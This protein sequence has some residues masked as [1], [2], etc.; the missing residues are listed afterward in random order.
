MQKLIIRWLPAVLLMAAIFVFS[1]IPSDEL[2]DFAWADRLVKKG[3]HAL[4][5]G[6]LALSYARGL[7]S[8]SRPEPAPGRRRRYLVAFLLAVLYSAL[9]EF[10][11]SFTP[12]RHP[13]PWD[14]L[15]DSGGAALALLW[16]DRFLPGTS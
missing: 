14:V 7:R 4:G 6:L 10:H 12:G 3:G 15:I 5:Y 9:D 13:S 2:P 1:S 16:A 8:K 11:Q